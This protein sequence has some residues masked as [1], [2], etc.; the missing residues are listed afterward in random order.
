MC[1]FHH[2]LFP[3]FLRAAGSQHKR[4][5]PDGDILELIA[6]LED[7]AEAREDAHRSQLLEHEE[8]MEEIREQR[9]D[10][11]RQ[12]EQE[13]E[14]RI[15]SMFLSFFE[16]L[17]QQFQGFVRTSNSNPNPS[18]PVPTSPSEPCGSFQLNPLPTK[19]PTSNAFT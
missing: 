8:R 10:Q 15:L 1:S 3:R 16:Q 6:R 11:R 9:E 13:H 14:E 4:K 18:H 12:R 19:P 7:A 17:S 5:V 2:V